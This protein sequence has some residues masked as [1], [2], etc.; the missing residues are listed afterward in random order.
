MKSNLMRI[1]STK[2]FNPSQYHCM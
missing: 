1:T 2:V